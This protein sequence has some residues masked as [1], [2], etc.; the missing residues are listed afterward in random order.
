M[1]GIH[2]LGGKQ[3]F[4]PV[5]RESDEPV[6][7]ARWEGRVFGMSLSGAG[8]AAR[9]SDHFRHAIERIDPVAYL[10]HGYYGRWLGG[11]EIRI[12][13]AGIL[14]SAAITRRAIELGAAADDSVAARP[15][16]TPDRIDYPAAEPHSRRPVGGSPRFRI[17]DRVRTRS[18]GVSGHTRLPAYAR[19][20]SGRIVTWHD[21]WVFPDS[22][23]HGRG[24]NPQHLYTV[25]FDGHELWGDDS[26]AG[27]VVHLDLFEPY[28]DPE[29]ADV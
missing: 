10:T 29:H 19:G 17:G 21:G 18:H 6:F 28:L 4:G 1:D 26:E 13:E 24:E 5:T 16:P 3:G 11:L 7:H 12:V 25:A 15:S 27:I 20:R 14:D 9:N 22:N 23:A 2:D 8:G